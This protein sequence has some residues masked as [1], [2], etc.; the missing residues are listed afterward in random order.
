MLPTLFP[1]FFGTDVK[2]SRADDGYDVFSVLGWFSVFLEENVL[3]K[4]L[5]VDSI[6]HAFLVKIW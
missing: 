1:G 5:E 6:L 4:L 2:T 3:K